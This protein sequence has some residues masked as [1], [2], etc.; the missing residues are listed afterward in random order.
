[1]FEN[2]ER[3]LKQINGRIQALKRERRKINDK[4]LV[5]KE[6]INDVSQD[7]ERVRRQNGKPN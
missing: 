2:P 3:R 5:L 7:L 6:A 4:L 1:M